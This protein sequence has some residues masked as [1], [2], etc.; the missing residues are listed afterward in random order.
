M[1]RTPYKRGRVWEHRFRSDGMIEVCLFDKVAWRR[2]KKSL[3]DK[4]AG[5]SYYE[6]VETQ[7]GEPR[8]HSSI[9]P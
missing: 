8:G 5:M 9:H 7:K 6:C 1:S 3:G 4:C 2:I